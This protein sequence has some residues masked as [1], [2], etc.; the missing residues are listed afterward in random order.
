LS[1]DFSVVIPIYCE[2]E[3]LEELHRRLAGALEKIGGTSEIIFVNDA[4]QDRSLELMRKLRRGDPRV[5]IISFSRNFGHQTAL[6]A[7]MRHARGRAVALMD[8]DLQDPPEALPEMLSRMRETKAEVV[9]AVRRKRKE[10]WFIRALYYLFYRA[11]QSMSYIDIPT[12]AGDFCIMSRRAVDQLNAM[13]ERSRFVRG[14]RSW[15][16]FRQVGF[17]YEREARNA[18]APKY[19]F[20]GLARLALDA[21]F[22]FS[23]VPLRLSTLLGLGISTLGLIYAAWIVAQ[24][25]TGQFQAIAGWSTVVVSVLVLGG[26]QLIML[27]IMGEYL[28]RI[29]EELKGRPPYV[30]DE[31]IGF[32]EDRANP[33]PDA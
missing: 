27:G 23:F 8:G 10:N 20:K 29:Y 15:V 24:R 31:T 12:D 16:G 22:S 18:G 14:L 30:I 13:P 28:G 1:V 3:N 5:R 7:G 32:D 33:E 26:A 4:S 21:F 9:Y 17:E 25:V 2:E 6:T 19:T 11:L